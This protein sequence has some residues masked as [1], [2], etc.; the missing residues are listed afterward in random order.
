MLTLALWLACQGPMG[1][2]G[3]PGGAGPSGGPGSMG[4][5]GPAGATG[6]PGGQGDNGASGANGADG[7]DGAEGSDWTDTGPTVPGE[8]LLEGGVYDRMWM[9]VEL[10][11]SYASLPSFA[12]YRVY[13]DTSAAVDDSSEL[14]ADISD[15]WTPWFSDSLAAEPTERFYYRVYTVDQDGNAAASNVLAMTGLHRLERTVGDGDVDSPQDVDVD[16]QGNIYVA[17][18]FN[19]AVRVYNSAGALAR[20]V[21]D[22]GNGN[23]VDRPVAVAW[24]DDGRLYVSNHDIGEVWA[25]G[26]GDVLERTI[27]MAKPAGLVVLAD[28]TALIAATEANQWQQLRPDGTIEVNFGCNDCEWP[29]DVAIDADGWIYT[30]DAQWRALHIWTPTWQWHDTWYLYGTGEGQVDDAWSMAISPLNGSV[31]VPDQTADKI[32]IY[33]AHGQFLGAITDSSLD[34]PMGLAFDDQGH[35][36]VA[37]EGGDNVL[38]FGP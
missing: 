10:D 8:A 16:S 20:T 15:R 23:D 29:Y 32:N 21:T 27:E 6:V 33:S 22:D 2:P 5:P 12:A 26:S 11:W 17:D 7:T 30:W 24:G 13:R 4:E 35:L 38:V 25:L 9:H 37:N 1:E 34:D 3:L 14:V 36:Y 28:G 18:T 19:Q 31:Y